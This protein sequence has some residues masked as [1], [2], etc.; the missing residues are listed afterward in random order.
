[1]QPSSNVFVVPPRKTLRAGQRDVVEA[2]VAAFKNGKRIFCAQ[3]PTGY[4]KTL[5]AAA[6]FAEARSAGLVDYLLYLVPTKIQLI[7]FCDGGEEDFLDVG[8]AGV[9]PVDV[10]YEDA[11]LAS[12]KF[13]AG[14]AIVFAATIQS[15]I[16][17]GAVSMIVRDMMARGRFMASPDEYHHYGLEKSWGRV[18][19]ELGA[20]CILAQSATPER[21][22]QDSAFGEPEV[23]VS[24]RDALE[25]KAVKEL[26]LHAY[27]YRVDAVTVNDEVL[28]FT[29]SDVQREVGS[30]DPAAIDKFVVDRKRPVVA[31]VHLAARF[32]SDRASLD[33]PSRATATDDRGGDGMSARQDGLRADSRH[34][35]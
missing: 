29:T 33:V 5:T 12:K 20:K 21:K 1:M 23:R 31:K 25:E 35:R 11:V 16:A 32:D 8:L 14:Q 6:V 2:A 13:R 15:V 27:E 7:Q 3:L 30:S 34:V 18:I 28:S 26:R 4:G 10:G 9:V 22:D 24:Y 19:M 17:G